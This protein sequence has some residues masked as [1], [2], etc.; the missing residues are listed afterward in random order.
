MMPH[1]ANLCFGAVH[2]MSKFRRLD[3]SRLETRSSLLTALPH[4]HPQID[5]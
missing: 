3:A 5:A 4:D 1:H 2:F